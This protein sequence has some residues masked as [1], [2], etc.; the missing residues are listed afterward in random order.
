MKGIRPLHRHI[1][2]GLV[3]F[4]Q[5]TPSP[6]RPAPFDLN[7]VRDWLK[8]AEAHQPGIADAPAMTVSRFSS[9]DLLSLA[10]TFRGLFAT[11][12]AAKNKEKVVYG[13]ETFTVPQLRGLLGLTG[14]EV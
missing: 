3:L 14:D 13:G 6:F 2:V 8:A 9:T 5:F 11:L 10:P 12:L 7:R 1:G 4:I